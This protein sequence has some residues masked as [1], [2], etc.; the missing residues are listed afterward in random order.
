VASEP[1]I[2]GGTMSG[3]VVVTPSTG[4]AWATAWEQFE[5]IR[6]GMI[7]LSLTNYDATT[8]PQIA[9]G[10]WIEAA[11]SIYKWTGNDSI[12]GSLT[13]D[14]IN[15]VTMVP[16]GS[17]ASAILTPTWSDSAPTWSD[18]YQGFYS[19]TTR[20]AGG[21]YYDGTNYVL[22]WVYTNRHAGPK[23]GCFNCPF[24]GASDSQVTFPLRGRHVEALNPAAAIEAWIGVQFPRKS[25]I[26]QLSATCETYV[27]GDVAITLYYADNADNGTVMA[28]VTLDAVETQTDSTIVGPV[29]DYDNYKYYVYLN[30]ATD[31]TMNVTE[32]KIAYTE[33]VRC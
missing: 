10:S 30:P 27:D 4:A 9:S 17:G 6:K 21:C 2:N 25:I 18:A 19:G 22:K 29:I 28:T 31:A 13:S 11:G 15:Y 26:T 14:A 7:S 5:G 20:Y 32:V 33:I 12:T 24:V 8:V 16:S 1:D 23:T 3:A